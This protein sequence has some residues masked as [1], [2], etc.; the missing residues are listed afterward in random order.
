M[1]FK[2]AT[3]IGSSFFRKLV[4]FGFVD[5][6]IIISVYENRGGA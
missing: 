1:H 2:G 5:L 4:K 6:K 3:R